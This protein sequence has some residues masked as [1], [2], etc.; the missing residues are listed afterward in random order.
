MSLLMNVLFGVAL[1][2]GGVLCWL[3]VYTYFHRDEPGVT[4]FAGTALTLGLGALGGTV[5]VI[6]RG[7]SPLEGSLPLWINIGFS[8]WIL[9]MAVWIVFAL[10]YTGRY[11]RFRARSVAAIALPAVA[12]AMLLVFRSGDQN[13]LVQVVGTLSTLYVFS[14]LIVSSYLLLRTSYRY[15]HLSFGQGIVL[16]LAGAF[17]LLVINSLSIFEEA[18][19]QTVVFGLFALAF[20]GPAVM[21]LLAV[22]YYRMFES[23]PAVGALGEQAIPRETD[24]LII[25]VDR[26]GRVIK[27][28]ETVTETMDV[29]PTEP[30]GES[31]ASLT[32]HTVEKLRR[33]ETVTLQTPVGSRKFDPEVS[34]FTDQ[35]DRQ[36]GT[37]LSLRDVSE[38][39]IRKQRLEVLNRVL[40]HNL[41]NQVDVIKS[42]AEAVTSESEEAYIDSIFESADELARLST[43]A[44]STDQLMSRPVRES[45][46]DLVTMFHDIVNRDTDVSV[47]LETPDS[48][49]LVTDWAALETALES[50]IE[51]AIQ[52]AD[53]SVTISVG[54]HPDGY[55]IT[56]TDDGPGIP[57]SEIESIDT[58]SETPLQH[59]TGLGLW[60][61]KWGLAKLNGELAID[62]AD[63]TTVRMTV[64]DRS[65]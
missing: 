43:K 46:G 64:P 1:L 50:A 57:E 48:A 26:D 5:V 51:N 8:G 63:G 15:G 45:T 10:E 38:R 6:D 21:L 60:Q 13:E 61:L 14:L 29:S 37:L 58:G 30:L 52:Y 17:P 20:V 65:A 24:D 33:S 62:T 34:A 39:E 11:A 55:T 18:T 12:N 9:A 44:R 27:I 32:G 41:R 49:R 40:R 7:V 28:N 31:V 16:G 56:V 3:G 25:V 4:P 35:H 42:N 36:L 47:T 54:D 22:F 23:T 53:S 2:S 59:G 19:S